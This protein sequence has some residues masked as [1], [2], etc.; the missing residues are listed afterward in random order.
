MPRL[1]LHVAFACLVAPAAAPAGQVLASDPGA[2][3]DMLQREGFVAELTTDGVGD[4]LIDIRYYDTTFQIFFYGCEGGRSCRMIQFYSGYVA[5]DAVT[6][7]AVNAW[8][9]DRLYTR[10]YID[11]EGDTALEYEVYLGAGGLTEAD[12]DSVLTHWT[13]SLVAFEDHIGW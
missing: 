6:L 13:E 11:G 5:G 12:F 9:R 2:L 3:H 1:F 7:E 8:N 4:P 10:A